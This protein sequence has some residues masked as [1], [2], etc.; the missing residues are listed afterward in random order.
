VKFR[1]RLTRLER[2]L[3]P[4]SAAQRERQA[5]DREFGELVRWMFSQ[6]CTTAS[7]LI[8]A[9]LTVPERFTRCGMEDLLTAE[10][11]YHAMLLGTRLFYHED[12]R[13]VQQELAEL[14]RLGVDEQSAREWASTFEFKELGD[15][16]C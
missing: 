1:S 6:H 2:E 7:E 4:T 10:R 9:G 8:A 12:E 16:G 14:A 13:Y 15:N 11:A 3:P 5:R